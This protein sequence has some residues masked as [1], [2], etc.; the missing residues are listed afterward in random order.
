[1]FENSSDSLAVQSSILFGVV[2]LVFFGLSVLFGDS[3]R[4]GAL[5]GFVIAAAFAGAAM[6]LL[7]R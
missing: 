4:R 3:I 5:Y 2:F 1:M 6:I 7:S